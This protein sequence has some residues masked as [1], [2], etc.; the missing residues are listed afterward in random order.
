M[1]STILRPVVLIPAFTM[2]IFVVQFF[3]GY[4]IE[5]ETQVF[6]LY[7]LNMIART[8][9][10]REIFTGKID[11]VV[12]QKYDVPTKK[13]YESRMFW[14]LLIGLISAAVQFAG[15]IWGFDIEIVKYS[16]PVL[17]AIALFIG[18]VTKK[19]VVLK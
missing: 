2:I 8:L 14:V 13:L 16:A 7:T 18:F 17:S 19:P 9:T 3:T 4:F 5:P 12:L 6:I 11:P 15:K 10:G 1:L